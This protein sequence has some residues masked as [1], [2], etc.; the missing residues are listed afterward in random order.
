MVR[1]I[2]EHV[3]GDLPIIASGGVMSGEDAVEKMK[4]GAKLVQLYTGF[5]YK[6]PA[7]IAESSEAVAHWRATQSQ[8]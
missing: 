7:L 5:I 3:K 6:G 4:A 8:K 1:L 2:A